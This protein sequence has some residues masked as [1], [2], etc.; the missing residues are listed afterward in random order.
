MESEVLEELQVSF[1]LI[2]LWNNTHVNIFLN[3]FGVLLSRWDYLTEKFAYEKRVKENKLKVAMMQAKRSNAEIVEQIEKSAVAKHVQERKRKRD[4][5]GVEGAPAAP[6]ES[7]LD[8]SKR[9]FRQ[10]HAIGKDYG[11]QMFKAQPNLLSK[12]FGATK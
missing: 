5:D 6:Q 12:V 2:Q 11:E 4:G 10:Q 1:S 9:S 8:K 7:A 3:P